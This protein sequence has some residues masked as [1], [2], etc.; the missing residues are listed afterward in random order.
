M[1]II[2]RLEIGGGSAKIDS[3]KGLIIIGV[4]TGW[5]LIDIIYFIVSGIST[6]K[7]PSTPVFLNSF[8][9]RLIFEQQ[10]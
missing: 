8:A 1:T 3:M 10:S 5:T 4:H 2:I 7:V 9:D 6:G